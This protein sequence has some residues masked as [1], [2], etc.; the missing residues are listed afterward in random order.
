MLSPRMNRRTFLAIAAVSGLAGCVSDGESV[1]TEIASPTDALSPTGTTAE[2]TPTPTTSGEADIAIGDSELIVDSGR[3]TTDVAVEVAVSNQGDDRSGQIRLTAEWYNSAGDFL[4]S[5][6][7]TM[8]SLA[9]SETWLARIPFVG[10]Q[11][12][13]VDDYELSGTFEDTPPSVPDGVELRDAQINL[14]DSGLRI[15]GRVV[16]GTGSDLSYI[17]AHGKLYD[18]SDQALLSEYTNQSEIPAGE[19][20][21]F[22]ISY[23]VLDR[24]DQV[25][26]YEVVLSQRV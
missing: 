3:F 11:A 20:W 24:R 5:G 1:N 4:D 19:T 15:T 26:N 6:E 7:E 8:V 2:A 22:E 14:Q 16:N 10:T 21:A 13:Q 12:D 25:S 9:P 17:E 18:D 23:L